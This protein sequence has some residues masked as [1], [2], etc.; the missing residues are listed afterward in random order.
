MK[1]QALKALLKIIE[2]CDNHH[3]LKFWLRRM[4]NNKENGKKL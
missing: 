4:E 1:S 2:E 3:E